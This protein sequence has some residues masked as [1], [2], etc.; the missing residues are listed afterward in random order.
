MVLLL[1]VPAT[2]NLPFLNSMS[3]TEA[4]SRWAAIFLPFSITLLQARTM[5]EPP[6]ASEREP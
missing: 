3:S 5:A 2:V 4:S 6:T 1:S